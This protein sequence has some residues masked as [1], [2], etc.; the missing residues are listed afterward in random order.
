MSYYKNM[1]ELQEKV[2][3]ETGCRNIFQLEKVF[4]RH[5]DGVL[6]L[7]SLKDDIIKVLEFNGIEV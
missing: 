4:T 1:I 7:S 6:Q 2:F 3:K 5:C